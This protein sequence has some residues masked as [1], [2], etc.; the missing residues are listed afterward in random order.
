[1]LEKEGGPFLKEEK[2]ILIE[3]LPHKDELSFICLK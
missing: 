3:H 2:N 1:M